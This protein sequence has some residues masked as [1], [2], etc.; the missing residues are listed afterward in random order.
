M[1]EPLGKLERPEAER[2]RKGRKLYLVPL[3]YCGEEAPQEFRDRCDGYWQQAAGQ[4]SNLASKIGKVCR[5]Y[6]ESIIQSGEDGLRAVER[7]SPSSHRIARTHCDD[8]ASFEAVEEEQLFN[9]YVDW[10]RCLLIGFISEAVATMVS[11]C[12]VE[13]AK[14]RNE[15][16]AQRIAQTL[17][18]DEAGLL[19]IQEGHSVQFPADIEVFSVSPPALDDV[20]RW[21]R[22]RARPETQK[23]TEE[24]E[25]ASRRES[26]D[27]GKRPRKGT[28][29]RSRS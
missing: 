20:H 26:G 9:E 14:K 5:V 21:L 11:A 12:Y 24:G 22:D 6:H 16:M 28:R 27:V 25:D 19:F 2:F 17:G 18:E 4:L 1:S 8:G 13:V 3:V 7:V 23:A 29:R 15:Y 10:Q